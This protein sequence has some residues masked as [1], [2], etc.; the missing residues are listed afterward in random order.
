MA[1]ARQIVFAS[2]FSKASRRAFTTAMTLAKANRAT[3]TILHVIVPF[4]PIVPEQYVSPDT[5][6]QINTE[7]RRRSR[8]QLR[9]LT[10]RAQKA[11]VRV[12]SLLL[13][14]DPAQLIARTA[15]RKR[16]DLLIVG[17]HGRTGLAKFF[18]GSVA[19]RLVATASCPVVTVR[20][21]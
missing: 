3:L 14:G 2:D 15:R 19:N 12:V 18:V 13:E 10:A 20:G 1:L 5:W 17:T 6:E 8:Q 21:A 4:A 11:G 16:A 7:A 9:R